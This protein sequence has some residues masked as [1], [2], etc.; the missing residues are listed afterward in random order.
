M[1]ESLSSILQL[2]FNILL[3]T[4]FCTILSEICSASDISSPAVYDH[5]NQRDTNMHSG[6]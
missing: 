5:T 4:E 6:L 3:G 1:N 2:V